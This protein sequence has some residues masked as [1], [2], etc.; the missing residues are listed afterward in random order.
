MDI[1]SDLVAAVAERRVI[2]F[3]G[4]GFSAALGLPDWRDMLAK[5]A[6]ETEGSLPYDQL[7]KHTGEDFLQ[8][9]EYLYLKSDQRI[10]PLRHVIERGMPE[11]ANP[12]VSAAHVELVNLGAPQIYTTNYDDLL[13]STYRALGLPVN[14]VALG[15]DVAVAGRETTQVVKYHGDLRHENTLVLTESSYF[16]RLDFESAMDVK[17]RADLLGRSVLFMGYSFRDIN[18]RLIWFKLNQM[19][20]DIPTADRRQSY[21]VRLE[22]NPVLEELYEAVGLRTIVLD[23]P[24]SRTRSSRLAALASQEISSLGGFLARL[25]NAASTNNRIPGTRERLFASE[26]LVVQ[27]ER[28]CESVEKQAGHTRPIFMPNSASPLQALFER[29]IPP[30]LSDRTDALLTRALSLPTTNWVVLQRVLEHALDGEPSA[31]LTF[32]V[33]RIL[34]GLAGP[35]RIRTQLLDWVEL[36]WAKVWGAELDETQAAALLDK[37]LSECE[38]NESGHADADIAYAAYVA[39]GISSGGILPAGAVELSSRADELIAR[40]ASIYPAIEKM[41]FA[42][43][44]APVLPFVISEVQARLESLP[45]EEEEDWGDDEA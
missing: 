25:S 6:E 14:V 2:P 5:L 42:R 8:I 31:A 11:H 36:D 22:P 37:L 1:P 15:R 9:A 21:I 18:I 20:E 29:R 4:A 16:R 41:S 30:A 27:S 33:S 28:W 32:T 19:M 35:P 24:N 43:D 40:A 12:T 17:F 7:A 34:C 45:P 38:Y 44:V 10:G 26:D 13:E 23:A 39:R 3:V